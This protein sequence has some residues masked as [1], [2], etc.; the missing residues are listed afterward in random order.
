[1]GS[2]MRG[3]L[4]GAVVIVSVVGSLLMV[5]VGM[6]GVEVVRRGTTRRRGRVLVDRSAYSTPASSTQAI[7][8]TLLRCGGANGRRMPEH[9]VVAGGGILQHSLAL[10]QVLRP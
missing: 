4:G 2:G 9:D 7:V 6:V 1:M 3:R 8:E 5:V 10:P